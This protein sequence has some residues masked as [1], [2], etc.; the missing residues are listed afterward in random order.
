MHGV[1]SSCLLNAQ[2]ASRGADRRAVEVQGTVLQS[3]AVVI[4]RQLDGFRT[5]AGDDVE[6]RMR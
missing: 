4:R 3:N 2:R 1:S 5:F 6:R